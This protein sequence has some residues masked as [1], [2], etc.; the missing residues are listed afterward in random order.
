MVESQN[1]EIFQVHS[2]G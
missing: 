1:R 2:I